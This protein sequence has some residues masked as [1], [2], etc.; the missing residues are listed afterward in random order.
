MNP[1]VDQFLNKLTKWQL[2]LEKLRSILLETSLTEDM[3][4]NVP[5]YTYEGK[6][7]VGINGMKEY[8]S[9]AF[10]KGALLK[11]KA[12]ILIQATEHTQ[13]ARSIHFGSVEEIVE[14]E[15]LL[16]AYVLEAIEAEKSGAKVQVEKPADLP[17]PE[18]FQNRLDEVPRLKS[19][20]EAL[21][22]GRQRAYLLYFG[23][24][25]QSATRASRVEQFIPRILMG[26]GPND[27]L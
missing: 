18:E 25:K 26:K 4:W 9:I 13:A 7:V 27:P 5:I 23:Q 21:T 22:P 6:N 15:A 11:D 8:A 14:K 24:A 2:E 1:K 19:A 20:F 16:K 10:F 17:V 3:K 12:G